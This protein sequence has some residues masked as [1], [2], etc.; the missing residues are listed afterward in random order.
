MLELAINILKESRINI[1]QSRI[2]IL[3]AF[4]KSSKALDLFFFSREF[5]PDLDRTT[6]FRTLK[7]FEARGLIYHIRVGGFNKYL[8]QTKV[9]KHPKVNLAG[10][11]C[12]RCGKIRS[13]RTASAPMVPLPEGYKQDKLVII[14]HGICRS[15]SLKSDQSKVIAPDVLKA[16]KKYKGMNIK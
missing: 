13:L 14:M 8:Y 4:L 15:C 7:L 2:K 3:E 9:V 12:T 6:V 11:I 10:F 16:I 5:S 1:T